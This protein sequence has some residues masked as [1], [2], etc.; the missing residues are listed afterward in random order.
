MV[1]RDHSRRVQHTDLI[2]PRR[3][4]VRRNDYSGQHFGDDRLI[5]RKPS[6][7][8]PSPYSIPVGYLLN[9]AARGYSHTD[10]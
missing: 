7:S 4:F 9:D 2:H 6:K 8:T 10:I 5:R 1:E 3:F